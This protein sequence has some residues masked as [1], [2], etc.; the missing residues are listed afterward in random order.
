MLLYNG[1]HR[2]NKIT[3]SYSILVN[4]II[5]LLNPWRNKI[6]TFSGVKFERILMNC[7]WFYLLKNKIFVCS[8]FFALFY[9]FHFYWFSDRGSRFGIFIL[10]WSRYHE[11]KERER[12]EYTIHVWFKRIISRMFAKWMIMWIVQWKLKT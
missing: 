11:K 12:L 8:S 9:V 10:I 5:F 6:N 3:Y 7:L 1:A 2:T 4:I